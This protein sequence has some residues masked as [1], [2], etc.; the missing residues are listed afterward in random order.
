MNI[1]FSDSTRF[2]KD[3]FK[4]LKTYKGYTILKASLNPHN[5]QY[6]IKELGYQLRWE[7]LKYCEN[8][9]KVIALKGVE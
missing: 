9:I 4:E 2:R 3:E 5:S 6:C 8:Y 7:N 1:E